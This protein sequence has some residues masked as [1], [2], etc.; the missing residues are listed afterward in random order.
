MEGDAGAGPLNPGDDDDSSSP[1]PTAEDASESD[2]DQPP[3]ETDG[4][5]TTESPAAQRVSVVVERRPAR[6]GRGWVIGL[7]AVLLLLAAGA[8]A[9]GYLAL[10]Y[11]QDSRAV[12]RDNAAAMAAAKDC[13]TATQAPDAAAMAAAQR[14]I[15][16]CST[17]EF[18]AQAARYSG[19]LLQAYQAANAH[20]QVSEMRAAVERDNSDGSVD[21]LL[22]VRVRVDSGEQSQEHGYRLRV[23]MSRADGRYKVA[24]LDQVAK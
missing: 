24:K 17:G 13:V 9:G 16:E 14:K 15:I 5:I 22:A 11:H 3:E 6:L 2:A 8:V 10:R 7:C 4:G 20:L 18:G 1:A 12:A 21:L 23:T 19:E